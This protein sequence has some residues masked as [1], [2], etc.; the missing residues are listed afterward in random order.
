VVLWVASDVQESIRTEESQNLSQ[1]HVELVY[2]CKESKQNVLSRHVRL[3]LART[4][5]SDD[6]SEKSPSLKCIGTDSLFGKMVESITY[7]WVWESANG[8][9]TRLT[10]YA[11]QGQTTCIV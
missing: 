7:V 1:N 5:E 3:L 11:L 4:F 2:A 10:L 8:S 6:V 9:F